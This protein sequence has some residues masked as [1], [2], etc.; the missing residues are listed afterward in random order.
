[1]LLPSPLPLRRLDSALTKWLSQWPGGLSSGPAPGGWVLS[2]LHLHKVLTLCHRVR[3]VLPPS[4]VPQWG[5]TSLGSGRRTWGS[6][7]YGS[8]GLW[9]P[10]LFQPVAATLMTRTEIEDR[11]EL[12]KGEEKLCVFKLSTKVFLRIKKFFLSFNR[13]RVFRVYL[14]VC[15]Q[16]WTLGTSLVVQ[17]LRL[18]AFTAGG[19]GLSPDWGTRILSVMLCGQKKKS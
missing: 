3:Q 6:S 14:H 17:L 12:G 1:M 19:T 11:E 7:C 9:N 16:K 5:G 4:P 10:R 13:L 15:I 8:E 18:H 2:L